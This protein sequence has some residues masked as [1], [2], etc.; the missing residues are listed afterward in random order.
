MKKSTWCALMLCMALVMSLWASSLAE[1]AGADPN[2]TI[3]GFD[4]TTHQTIDWQGL[5]FSFP[6]YFDVREEESGTSIHFYPEEED[7]YASLIFQSNDFPEPSSE[8]ANLIPVILEDI[9]ESGIFASATVLRSEAITVAGMP[10]WTMHMTHHGEQD[11]AVDAVARFTFMHNENTGKVITVY[12]EYDIIDQ[13]RY[14]YL[15]DYEKIL[16]LAKVSEPKGS[17]GIQN[18]EAEPLDLIAINHTNSEKQDAQFIGR[19]YLITG[20]VYDAMGPDEWSD[21]AL[22]IIHPDVLAR[23]MLQGAGM[24]FPLEINIWMSAEEYKAIGGDTS[25]GKEIRV[26]KTLTSIA[27]NATSKDSSIRGY[28]IQLEFGTSTLY[29]D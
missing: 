8:F 4:E 14:D 26:V 22:V 15:G 28:P 19:Q 9:K 1:Q 23:G 12:L 11:E 6:S 24:D 29:D 27:R 5:V 20:I 2:R 13:S 21:D 16:Q 7:Y 25:V 17:Q 18:E 3:S 10:G